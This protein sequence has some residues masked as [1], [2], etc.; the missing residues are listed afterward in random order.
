MSDAKSDVA[1]NLAAVHEEIASAA[2]RA[3]RKPDE[4]RLVAVTKTKPIEM[5]DEAVRA[6]QLVFGENYPQEAARK[7][8]LRPSLEWHF[9]GGLQSN[10]VKL[11]AGRTKLIESVDRLKLGEEIARVA[12][13]LGVTQDVLVQVHIGEEGTKLGVAP[14]EG[15]EL[16][17]KLAALEGIR[18]RG[19]MSLPPLSDDERVARARFAE[20]RGH[21]EAWRRAL[22]ADRRAEFRELSMGTSHD[23]P[24]AIAEGATLVRVGTRLFGPR[25]RKA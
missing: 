3:G 5:I 9:I 17:T 10:K 12:Q 25:E 6:G 7:I 18:V 4:V 23:F 22:P 2:L 1:A 15:E 8:E 20:L 16:V 14:A 24:W 19:L 21:L 13:A 11:V